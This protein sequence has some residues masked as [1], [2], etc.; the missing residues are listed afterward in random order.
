VKFKD[1]EEEYRGLWATCDVG[2]RLARDVDRCARLIGEGKARYDEVVAGTSIPWYVVGI[3]HMMEASG[4]WDRHLHNGDPLTARTYQ[5][6][7]NRPAVG[8]PPFTWVESAKDALITLKKLDEVDEWTV[9]RVAYELERYNGWGYRRHHAE[10][11]SPY[12]WSG[13][14]HYRTGKYVRDG[15]WSPTAVSSQPGAMAILKRLID[16]DPSIGPR[17]VPIVAAA[18]EPVGWAVAA[19]DER[20]SPDVAIADIKHS[21]RKLR[22]LDKLKVY[23]GVGAVGAGGI[24]VADWKGF[25]ADYIPHL[26]QLIAANGKLFFAGVLGLGIFAVLRLERY[27]KQ[28]YAEGRY[29]PRDPN[30]GEGR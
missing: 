29:R 7:A 11:L 15:K 3:I 23:M 18:E 20:K 28:D 5:V 6:P 16:R 8:E 30:D 4:K 19:S 13:T 25:A 10:C 21:S 2:D 24:E 26:K 17:H 14:G 12:L 1:L 22:L 27:L 9:E